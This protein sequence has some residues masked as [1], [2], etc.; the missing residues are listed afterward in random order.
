M[1]KI[2]I[3]LTPD[4]IVVEIGDVTLTVKEGFTLEDQRLFTEIEKDFSDSEIPRKQLMLLFGLSEK[5]I[6]DISKK[7]PYRYLKQALTEAWTEVNYANFMEKK[8][9]GLKLSKSS[10]PSPDSSTLSK[11]AK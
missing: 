3:D 8:T 6:T 2:E 1:P 11:P 4:P 9:Q 5:E 7:I 10:K